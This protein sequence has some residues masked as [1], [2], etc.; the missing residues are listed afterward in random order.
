MVTF[1]RRLQSNQLREVVLLVLSLNVM[2]TQLIGTAKIALEIGTGRLSKVHRK[3]SCERGMRIRFLMV[4]GWK[5][6]I[7]LE[8]GT[9]S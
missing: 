6:P 8:S 9:S 7:R 3:D 1:G 5:Q 4:D 2:Y